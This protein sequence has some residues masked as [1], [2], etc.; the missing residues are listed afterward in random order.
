MLT[1]ARATPVAPR[2]ITD[3]PVTSCL[4]ASPRAC[5]ESILPTLTGGLAF[6]SGVVNV[7]R[8]YAWLGL[9]LF[10]LALSLSHDALPLHVKIV[11]TSI[12]AVVYAAVVG[13]LAKRTRCAVRFWAGDVHACARLCKERVLRLM[14]RLC[15]MVCC[16][17]CCTSS[18]PLP[19][20]PTLFLSCTS[21]HVNTVPTP[22]RPNPPAV[23]RECQA[24]YYVR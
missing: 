5:Q 23:L 7:I 3:T 13:P 20:T 4:G 9:Y 6:D 2:R 17:C 8:L 22:A 11:W 10:P 14:V 21:L 12:I 15:A 19:P 16:P 18:S 1:T 24:A